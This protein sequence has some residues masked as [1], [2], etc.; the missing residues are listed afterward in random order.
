MSI[1]NYSIKSLI[2]TLALSLLPSFSHAALTD[3][4]DADSLWAA[5]EIQAREMMENGRYSEA[6]KFYDNAIERAKTFEQNNRWL[7]ESINNLGNSYLNLGD[8]L[9][10][11]SLYTEAL[12]MRVLRFGS[13]H[14]DV[15][16]SYNNM[17]ALYLTLGLDDKAL[18]M[19]EKS[20]H[21]IKKSPEIDSLAYATLIANLGVS[22]QAVGRTSEAKEMLFEGLEVR[23]HF[24]E[25]PYSNDV[26]LYLSVT[27]LYI[28]EDELDSAEFYAELADSVMSLDGS[29]SNRHRAALYG[30]KAQIQLAR[31]DT[32][33][34]RE[35]YQT[36]GEMIAKSLGKSHPD[37]G[38]IVFMLGT[39][40]LFV[41][42]D[43]IKAVKS[44]ETAY[45]IFNNSYEPS[46]ILIAQ[47]ASYLL[48]N[49][50]MLERV[51]DGQ[52]IYVDLFA[53][54][55]SAYGPQSP[56]KAQLFKNLMEAHLSFGDYQT[57]A[58]YSTNLKELSEAHVETDEGLMAAAMKTQVQ[59]YLMYEMFDE[60]LKSSTRLIQALER[61]RGKTSP[62][63]LG[64]LA[65]LAGLH[66]LVGTQEDAGKTFRRLMYIAKREYGETDSAI[67][68][69]YR[70]YSAY[71][72]NVGDTTLADSLLNLADK[73]APLPVDTTES[74]PEENTEDSPDDNVDED[75]DEDEK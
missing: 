50:V 15:A 16:E 63:L 46:N 44:F 23:S 35:L 21:I 69:Y 31:K 37:Y 25:R 32:D 18:I 2:F 24:P 45:E 55:D 38:Q 71:L 42:N 57:A 11:E 64:P 34:A 14:Q 13:I 12:N 51:A 1:R 27:S 30:T 19:M 47:T 52:K 10:A 65:E 17:G 61:T 3:N 36:G 33:K 4:P 22:F 53:K 20:L 26:S 43:P 28:S 8:F 54:V 66:R 41:Q 40:D 70:I 72:Q 67:A 7:A 75:E 9:K 49:Y 74:A 6:R 58:A 5:I 73:I 59:I 39:L 62:T 48:L 29:E 68:P 60:A 56:E